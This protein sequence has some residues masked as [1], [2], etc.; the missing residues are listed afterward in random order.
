MNNTNLILTRRQFIRRAAG[1]AFTVAAFPTIIPSS[2]L[3]A[4]GAVAPSNRITVACLGNGP[5]GQA[6]MG[7][8]LAQKDAQVVAVC[9]VKTEQVEQ[10]CGKVNARYQN[11][12]C[13]TYGDFREVLARKDIDAC[14]ISSPD[15]WHVVMGI[16]AVK[17]GKDV[18]VEKPLGCSLAEGQAMRKAVQKTKRIF[19]F[20]TQQR[21]DQKFRKA[22]AL[23]RNGKLGKL[24]HVNV[25]AP[26][27]TPGGSTKVVPVPDTLNYD[28]WLGPAPFKPYA[29]NRC[30]ADGVKKTWW[31]DSDYALGFI[32]G[33]G[34]HPMDIAIW[35]AGELMK[36][37]VEVE[38]TGSYPTEGACNTATIWDINFKFASGLTVTFAGVP[39]GGNAGKPTGEVWPHGDEWKQKY[40][41]LS[42]HGTVFEGTDG[43]VHVNRGRLIAHPENLEE[44]KTDDPPVKLKI[45]SHHVRDFLDSIR[46][47]K[48]A[49]SPV[50][51]AVW[52]DALCHIADIAARLKRKVTFDFKTERFVK[53]T[54]ANKR[55]ALRA[56]RSPWKV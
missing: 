10:A 48:P 44:T 34:I 2:A 53:D 41:Q 29:E 7:G 4:D 47:R 38:G 9:D 11:Q 5:Q 32:A 18:Y 17:A 13:K 20:G 55:L 43:W 3:G 50:E 49:V 46:S 8:F 28:F 27:S 24:K 56:L 6:V 36:G 19:Q 12:D 42:S 16:A 45:S 25:W 40:G 33:W 14:L 1:A 54:E 22:C 35:G 39:N 31:F 37:Q 52:G 15:H 21:S 51:D 26:G 23:A 30:D